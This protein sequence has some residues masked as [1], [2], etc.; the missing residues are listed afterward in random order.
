MHELGRELGE[1]HR[2]RTAAVKRPGPRQPPLRVDAA[3]VQQQVEVELADGGIE[4]TAARERL[5]RTQL[6]AHVESTSRS[7]DSATH[8]I[9][10][11]AAAG[12][13]TAALR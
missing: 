13:P 5:D 10:G 12:P 7:V 8:E 9:R 4:T 1:R 2:A 11:N 3:T 6:L